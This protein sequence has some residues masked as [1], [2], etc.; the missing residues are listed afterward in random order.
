[1]SYWGA[2]GSSL[3]SGW[4]KHSVQAFQDSS[5]QFRKDS[6]FQGSKLVAVLSGFG[7]SI[8]VCSGFCTAL[9]RNTF[10]CD[11][12]S[13]VASRDKQAGCLADGFSVRY[14]GIF[15]ALSAKLLS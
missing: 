9:C 14:V 8:L 13:G 12:G 7:H 10:S 1:V 3:E 2:Q 11:L 6:S 4:A 15:P 5:H